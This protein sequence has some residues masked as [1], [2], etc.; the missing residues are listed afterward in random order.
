M[1]GATSF[2]LLAYPTKEKATEALN[3]I[4]DLSKT[5]A[6]T[7]KDAAV[8][9]H[10]PQGKIEVEQSRELSA[11]QGAVAGGVAGLLLGLAVG[12]VVPATLVGLAGGGAFGVFDTGIKN[13]RLRELGAQLEP[14]AA[15]LGL[16]V[17][18]ADWPLLRERLSRLGGEP[19]VLELS[20][21]ALAALHEHAKKGVTHASETAGS[22]PSDPDAGA[23]P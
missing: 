14:G 10:T 20:D 16:L 5:D 1:S 13:R 15:A 8:V 6:L 7:L 11:G 3:V 22:S 2:A 19:I 12:A 4:V 23:E 17:Q 18:G 21:E 9:V